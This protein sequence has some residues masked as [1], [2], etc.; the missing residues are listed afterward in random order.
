[1]KA[2]ALR[3][4]N[5]GKSVDTTSPDHLTVKQTAAVS[6]WVKEAIV[7][8]EQKG[9]RRRVEETL[10]SGLFTPPMIKAFAHDIR[11]HYKTERERMVA[12]AEK[13]PEQAL[14]LW[15]RDK[16][17]K[18]TL[19]DVLKARA[20]TTYVRNNE[21]QLCA[22]YALA[23]ANL[24]VDALKEESKLRSQATGWNDLLAFMRSGIAGGEKTERKLHSGISDKRMKGAK[25]IIQFASAKQLREILAY[26]EK[27]L[28]ILEKAEK[29]NAAEAKAAEVKGRKAEVHKLAAHRHAVNDKVRATFAPSGRI[30]G[31]RA[32]A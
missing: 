29:A 31:K 8:A 24:P 20:A 23:I 18:S 19:E 15:A 11:E 7:F 16:G 10:F 27:Q 3:T 30:V 32:A 6:A 22:K 17:E 21:W 4:G 13:Q 25:Q 9:R 2:T 1:M 28:A 5:K 12:F 26:A 14:L